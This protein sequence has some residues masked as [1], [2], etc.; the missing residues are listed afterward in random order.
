MRIIFAGTPDFA[1]TA[2]SLLIASTHTLAGVL[3]QPDRPAGRGKKLTASPVKQ[4]ALRAGLPVLQP[5]RLQDPETLQQLTS[6]EA[7]VMVVVAYGLLVPQFV[8][9]V[10]RYGCLNIH[11]S[12]LPRWR[13][14]APIQRAIAAGDQE[15]GVTIMQMDAGLDTGDMLTTRSTPILPEDTAGSLH[16]RL[17]TLGAQ[18]LLATLDN[19]PFT[20]T[21][22]D[23]AK[24]CYAPKLTK[25]EARLNW[26]QPAERLHNMVRAF[27][28][29]PVAFAELDGKP[30]RI[31]KSRP[32]S[33]SG[34]PGQILKVDKNGLLVA[35]GEDALLLQEIQ[36]P[37]GKAQ[38]VASLLNGLPHLFAPGAKLQ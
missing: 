37:G 18:A 25:Q 34:T 11:A 10:P 21:P 32:M 27:N 14:A 20:G 2:L 8:L 24:S 29:W 16:D 13:G 26:L 33:G 3:T 31:W 36:L 12:L 30:V 9:D 6:L 28:P 17:S 1:A 7:D 22:Q 38:P 23:N 35:C 4:L 15:T 19:L 5:A